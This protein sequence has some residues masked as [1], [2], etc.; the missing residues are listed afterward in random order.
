MK[1]ESAFVRGVFTD[2]FQRSAKSVLIEVAKWP[3]WRVPEMRFQ[4]PV[5][6]VLIE[7]L[8]MLSIIHKRR[9]TMTEKQIIRETYKMTSEIV[10]KL[11]DDRLF[12]LEDYSQAMQHLTNFLHSL[13][14]MAQELKGEKIEEISMINDI[15]VVTYKDNEGKTREEV[16]K[17]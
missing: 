2:E 5:K 17:V 9:S 15:P 16:L 4:R 7:N 13:G 1:L 8:T 6:S 11:S 12:V 14:K 10:N 3:A